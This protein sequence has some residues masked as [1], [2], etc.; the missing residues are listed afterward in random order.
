VSK[1][2]EDAICATKYLSHLRD[3][4]HE[5]PS[6]PRYQVKASLVDALALQ[7]ELKAG[8]VMQNIREMVVL[9]HE[10]LETSDVDAT[11]FIV[12]IHA[13]VISQI[14]P[15]VP[16]QPLDELIEFSRAARK[17]RPDLLE[18]H[19]TFAISLVHRYVVT[20]ANHDYE[21]ASSILDEIIA[22]S[23]PW[24]SRDEFVAKARADATCLVTA[25]AM[26]RS[27]VCQTPENVEEAIHRT[28]TCVSSP[29]VKERFPGPLVA[30]DP[31][32]TAKQRF[33]H[34]GS[35]EGVEE[36]SGNLLADVFSQEH[37]QT[38]G[39]MQDL[40]SG[41]RNT[42]DTTEIDEAIEEARSLA[43][44]SSPTDTLILELCGQILFEA[45]NRTKKIEYLNESISLRRREIETS[46]S[47]AARVMIFPSLALSLIPRS[48]LFPGYR[49]QD[50]DE[51]LELLSQYVSSATC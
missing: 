33:R 17:R 41:F 28:R 8:N 34:F 22:N 35:I 1:Q 3:Q 46:S 4:P 36:P 9:S 32:T 40:L 13:V 19:M 7:V 51:A 21:E 24:N 49:T 10:L 31:E 18:G 30:M 26:I 14:R 2:P 29:S 44:A 6:I 45:F 37:T 12:L 27:I 50:L 47:Q 16:G 25:L 48:L 11:H 43:L 42:D 5:I 20:C 38:I 23:S 39:R 15:A